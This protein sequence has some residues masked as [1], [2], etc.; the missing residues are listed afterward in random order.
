MSRPRREK[1]DLENDRLLRVRLDDQLAIMLKY[2]CEQRG[3]S[4]S[5]FVRESLRETLSAGGTIVDRV[6][7]EAM[8]QAKMIAFKVMN[9][10]TR[11]AC[12][13]AQE[14]LAD[15]LRAFFGD[16]IG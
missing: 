3:M 1:D 4:K 12:N 13:L 5:S 8:N 15:E 11:D 9:Q 7:L 10:A 2:A 14:R 16:D 6:G